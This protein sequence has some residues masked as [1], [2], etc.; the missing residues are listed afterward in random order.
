MLGEAAVADRPGGLNRYVG[1]LMVALSD[2][3]ARAAVVTLGPSGAPAGEGVALD[4]PLVRRLLDYRGR[5]GRAGD[6]ADLVDVHFALYALLP[7]LTSRLRRLPI[8]AHFHGPW[9]DESENAR[10]ASVAIPVKRAVERLVYRRARRVVTESEAFGRLVVEGYDVDPDRVVV[11]PPGV[12]LV[13]FS[14][15][16]RD[17]ARVRFGLGPR[18]FV[19]VAVRRLE[20]RMGLDTLM[21][22]WSRVQSTRPGA[23][24]LVAGEGQLGT[25]L[26][27]LR[28]NLPV[29]D[30]A[31][32]LGRVSDDDLVALYRAA[33][34]S[35]LPSHALEGFGLAALESLAC[36]TPTVVSDVG[37]LPEAVRGLDETLVLPPRDPEA[38][39]ERL[40]AAAGGVLP[41][42]GACRA[43]A[44]GFSWRV[45]VE[46]H[47]DLYQEALDR[48]R[49]AYVDHCAQRSG[50]EL[51]LARLLPALEVDAHVLLAEGGPLG[52]DLRAR[53]VTVEVRPM[54]AAGR[55]LRRHEVAARSFPLASSV[56]AAAYAASLA[57]R[58][59]GL[60]PELV[61]TNSLKAALYGGVAGRLAGI[62]VVW[63]LRDRITTEHLPP[64]AV[65]LVRAAGRV[66]PSAVIANS[67]ATL[68]TLGGVAGT[69]VPS[70]VE[71]GMGAATLGRRREGDSEFRVGMVGRLARW[72]GQHVFL[73]GFARAFP[74][75]EERAVVVGAPLFGADD[76]A[77]AG[78]L[79]EQ[80]R[81]LGLAGR[82]DFRGHQDDIASVYGDLD[83]LVHASTA[84]EP[85][86]LVVAEG[87][88]AGLAVV[89]ADAG[90]PAEVITPG[91][92][93]LLYPPGDVAA[94]A[95]HLETLRDDAKLRER[96][97]DGG[98]HRAR[99]FTPERVGA[100][101]G[102]VYERVLR[103]RRSARRS[104]VATVANMWC[105]AAAGCRVFGAGRW[106][107]A[108][109]VGASRAMVVRA[110]RHLNA[111]RTV[112]TRAGTE[113][114][115]RLNRGDLQSVREVWLEGRYRLPA[116]PATIVDL[117]ANIGLTTL[118]FH[119]RWPDA[120]I[121]AVEPDQGNLHVLERNL[122]RN[123]VPG[124]LLCAAVGA[125]AGTATFLPSEESNLGHLSPSS[126]PGGVAVDVVTMDHV[127]EQIG[128]YAD[129]LK[130]D[131]EGGEQEL[132][133]DSPDWLDRVGTIV[134]E[135]HPPDVDVPRLVEAVERRGFA[136]VPHRA[137]ATNSDAFVRPG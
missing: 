51:A 89:A 23:V 128:G 76:E 126:Q 109:D 88:A 129:L 68:A 21:A 97:G 137:G 134:I 27:S 20:P 46:R 84:P 35:V 111:E 37:G 86:G 110:P 122:A 15:G 66:L 9:A 75:G 127:L 30:G 14:P 73:S 19:A 115:Y 22:A 116:E 95:T 74:D 80:V 2:A 54:G 1:D 92:D 85:F 120:R 79:H 119:E 28:R 7:L 78:E 29:P 24:L 5:A 16:D 18:A 25:E 44:E 93:G 82:V 107:Y 63:H 50:A 65:V 104:L 70:P 91:V 100:Q 87:M 118:W 125:T 90:G 6:H 40:V 67:A 96:L 64:A 39:G 131:I 132:L 33:D 108:A 57:R 34:C 77:Y 58:L 17:A 136:F 3:G 55:E 117:G 101:V 114:T 71:P 135:F 61:H 94:L 38:L 52:D 103:D 26:R 13:R 72:K 123:R 32:F 48:P 102:D 10:G 112:V 45:A 130:I 36:G 59:R 43:H 41:S 121:V 124:A 81:R 56:S 47:L 11:I 133:E 69:V 105:E 60:R 98:R 31:R 113:V 8:V 4:A 106:R 99:A 62:P 53:G 12:D 42:R 49:V 83:V